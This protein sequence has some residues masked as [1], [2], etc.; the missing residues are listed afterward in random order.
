MSDDNPIEIINDFTETEHELYARLHSQHKEKADSD[1]WWHWEVG[2]EVH[3]ALR[4]ARANKEHYGKNVLK[5]MALALGYENESV[6][7]T[8][9]LV[10]DRWPTKAAFKEVLKLK[11]EANDSLS[12]TH[13]AHLAQLKDDKMFSK[14]AKLALEKGLTAR[15]LLQAIQEQS[16]NGRKG[17][18]GP[19]HKVPDNVSDAMKHINEASEKY[20]KKFDNSWFCKQFNLAEELEK[21]PSDDVTEALLAQVQAVREHMRDVQALLSEAQS[22]LVESETWLEECLTEEEECSEEEDITLAEHKKQQRATAKAKKRKR[23]GTK[24]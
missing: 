17:A 19:K 13:L 12:W 3:T 10:Y 6:L 15:Q 7:N 8:A 5:R 14:L 20:A 4:D 9:A 2:K 22:S 1:R 18:G 24:K 21:V 23:V 11:N 16:N